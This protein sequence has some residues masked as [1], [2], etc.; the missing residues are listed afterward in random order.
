MT[1]VGGASG[2]AGPAISV[3]ICTRNRADL[4]GQ[5]M[6]SVVSQQ[7][8]RAEF[9]IIVV[10]NASTDGTPDVAAQFTARLPALR[11]RPSGAS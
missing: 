5:A 8:P 10:D 3:V 11:R 9:E 6:A 1:A 7:F 2:G 4:L